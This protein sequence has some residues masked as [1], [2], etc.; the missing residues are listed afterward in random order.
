VSERRLFANRKNALLSTGPKTMRGK[1]TV[2]RNA[3]THGILARE[4]V[5]T[6]GDGEESQ[7]EFDAL[8]EDLENGY[9]P[10][11]AVEELHVQI[12]A[13]AL[14]RKARVLRAENGEIRRQL[15]TSAGNRALRNSDKGN[16]ALASQEMGSR[17]YNPENQTD[18][19]ISTMDRWTAAQVAQS[20]ARE[21]Q[22]GLEYLTALLKGAKSEIQSD[23][24]IS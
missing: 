1:R 14:W 19:K 23:G 16:F 7:E 17:L 11:W 2:S 6:A 15:D 24:Y 18:E 21:S 13:T 5:I 10:V 3:S 12:I 9:Q 8:I 20:N 22:S 4:V